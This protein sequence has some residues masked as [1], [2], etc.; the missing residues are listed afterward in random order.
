MLNGACDEAV[1]DRLILFHAQL[2]H[3]GSDVICRKE[4]QQIVFQG[5]IEA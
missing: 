4:A 3:N 5:K 1:L 2:I